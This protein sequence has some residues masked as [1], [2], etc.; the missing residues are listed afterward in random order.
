MPDL[1]NRALLV[2]LLTTGGSWFFLGA[3]LEAVLR[4]LALDG[5]GWSVHGWLRSTAF[6]AVA[7]VAGFL[8]PSPAGLGVRE[9][10]LQQFLAPDLGD[11]IAVVVVLLLR[12]LWTVSECVV[13]AAFAACGLAVRLRGG[14]AKPQ[15][16]NPDPES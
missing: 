1:R 2:G 14:T 12:L 11:Q 16:A 7:N 9:F 3:S 6:V 15:A 8:T 5:S 13:A 10:L 4:A